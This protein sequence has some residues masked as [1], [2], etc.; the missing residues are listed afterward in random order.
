[1]F[2]VLSKTLDLL[3]D[4]WWWVAVPLVLGA[5]ALLRSRRRLG[6]G[7][8]GTGLGLFTLLS[9]PSVSNRLWQ[10]LEAD[11]VSTMRTDATYDVVVLLGG[12][13]AAYGATPDTVS[14]GDNVERLT[15]TFDLLRQ[16]KAQHVIVSG[17][18]L[19]DGL[20]TEAGYLAGQLEAWGIE[21]ERILV[22][23][24]ARNTVENAERSKAL[25]DARGFRSVLLVTS[26]FH[27]PRAQGCF[28]GVGLEPDVLPVDFR[29][30]A[31]GADGHWL[32]RAGY[33]DDSAQAL[34]ELFGRVTYRLTGKAK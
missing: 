16:G 23:P 20:P 21:K 33:F 31:P 29:M 12:T 7:L 26:A 4:P 10:A 22:E 28:R 34:R 3:V 9:L 17:G 24:E 2:F 11:A 8:M 5:V 6:L 19:R 1:M 30:R 14:W 32:P 13:V 18:R 15:V 25:I 27:L